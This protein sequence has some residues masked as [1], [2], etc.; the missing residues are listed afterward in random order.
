MFWLF[1]IE[2]RVSRISIV[3][4]RDSP[5]KHNKE[6]RLAIQNNQHPEK[7][8]F[9]QNYLPSIKPEPMSQYLSFVF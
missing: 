2:H 5:P 1:L 6:Y 4:Q 7:G 9:R 8:F 3:Q